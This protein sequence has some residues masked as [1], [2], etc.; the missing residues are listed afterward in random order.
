MTGK[1]PRR[2]LGCAPAGKRIAATENEQ[3]K[4]PRLLLGGAPATVCRNNKEFAT[5]LAE[6]LLEL[7]ILPVVFAHQVVV[8]FKTRK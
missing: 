3:G 1:M 6:R 2:L 8:S 7:R 4:M 5:V